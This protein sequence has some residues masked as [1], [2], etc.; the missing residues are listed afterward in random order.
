MN[1][2]RKL[3]KPLRG[4]FLRRCRKIGWLMIFLPTAL[5]A[6]GFVMTDSNIITLAPRI[7]FVT[8]LDCCFNHNFCE[9]KT[10]IFSRQ[11][12]TPTMIYMSFVR[13]FRRCWFQPSHH[14]FLR[15]T[16]S[17]STSR[18]WN[19]PKLSF[20]LGNLLCLQKLLVLW[21]LKG[22]NVK[23]FL[24][25]SKIS[26]TQKQQQ[27]QVNQT[28][29]VCRSSFRLFISQIQVQ[30]V[31]RHG[32]MSGKHNNAMKTANTS[33]IVVKPTS[34][35]KK[36]RNQFCD[37]TKSVK[38]QRALF[39]HGQRLLLLTHFQSQLST[40]RCFKLTLQFLCCFAKMWKFC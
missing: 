13:V 17:L 28:P 22:I 6:W 10:P 25:F 34:S 21:C 35:K 14:A 4:N 27:Q 3:C 33:S 39:L 23:A 12:F 20:L 18:P 15:V 30:Q 40:F 32:K 24:R 7:L 16:K 38:K 36:L 9:R 37:V 31:K 5:A 1:W 19:V 29:R 2:L 11:A 26:S 8:R